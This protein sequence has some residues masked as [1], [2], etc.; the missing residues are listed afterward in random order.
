MNQIHE[1]LKSN[2]SVS[3][4]VKLTESELLEVIEINSGYIN[5]TVKSE[6][7]S[8]F[9]H[10]YRNYSLTIDCMIYW[11]LTLIQIVFPKCPNYN[12]GE[13]LSN[14]G[15][16]NQIWINLTNNLIALKFLFE[17]GL[18]TQAKTIFRSSIELADLALIVL[19]DNEYFLSHSTPQPK[20]QGNPFISPKNNTLT[21]KAKE[22]IATLHKSDSTVINKIWE[23]LRVNQYEVLSETSHGNFLHNVLNAYKPVEDNKFIPS[24]GGN[25]WIDLDRVLSDI[26]LHHVTLKRHITWILDSKHAIDLFD[27][28][29]T[30]HKFIFYLDTVMALKLLGKLYDAQFE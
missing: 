3:P 26:C 9:Q 12:Q 30:P 11:N 24:I 6:L 29:T 25:K 2:L 10:K 16:F 7:K 1:F 17:S 14:L 21:T 4:Q 8:Y 23:G 13:N 28:K 19:Y 22:I 27:N 15:Y 5:N 20:K 18:D